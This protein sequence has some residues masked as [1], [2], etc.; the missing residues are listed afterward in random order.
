ML[1]SSSVGPSA[2]SALHA[3]CGGE[4]GILDLLA[5]PVA[6]RSGAEIVY[7]NH[8]FASAFGYARPSELLGR[9]IVEL[10]HPDDL[11]RLQSRIAASRS[12]TP[13]RHEEMRFLTRSG[14]TLVFALAAEPPLNL[15]DRSGHL[16]VARDI[17]HMKR[18]ESQLILADRLSS[19]GTLVAGVCHELN[20]P[21]MYV[22]TN[23]H[24]VGEGL[25]ERFAKEEIEDLCAALADSEEGALRMKKIV[26]DLR[27]FSRSGVTHGVFASVNTAVDD[28]IQ[29]VGDR[30][31][32]KALLGV[33]AVTVPPVQGDVDRLVQVFVNLLNNAADA[34]P[35]D[36]ANQN[37]ILVRV[38]READGRVLV[39]VRDTGGGIPPE[40]LARLWDPFFTTK[41]VGK[42]TGLGLAVCHRIVRDCGGTITVESEVGLGSV[43][44][45]HLPAVEEPA[46]VATQEAQAEAHETT[47]PLRVLVVDDDPGV[48]AGLERALPKHRVTVASGGAEAIRRL[49]ENGDDFD[50]VLCD[51]SMPDIDGVAVFRAVE[52]DRPEMV[53]KFIFITGG[54]AEPGNAEMARTGRGQLIYKPIDVRAIRRLLASQNRAER[55]TLVRSGG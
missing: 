14:E 54:V 12:G 36:A 40:H 3:L 5:D 30:V 46:A 11:S 42:G 43:F 27:V 35:E 22:L 53:E 31:R 55:D 21:L 39:E 38:D 37:Q 4:L 33:R 1:R 32:S 20:N 49:I 29:M 48:A 9:A 51:L 17:T 16:F 24:V 18:L 45:V 47:E 41:G 52:A 10:V 7:A 8:G 25:R 6:I 19:L 44:Q 13:P 2:R 23:I 50:V 34:I 28:A 26:A 15:G